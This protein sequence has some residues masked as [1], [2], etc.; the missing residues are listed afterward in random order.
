MATSMQKKEQKKK[1]GKSIEKSIKDIQLKFYTIVFLFG[2]FL[3]AVAQIISV[4]SSD[5]LLANVYSANAI[6]KSDYK[7]IDVSGISENGGSAQIITKNLGVI[8]LTGNGI[9]KEDK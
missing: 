6:I 7:S 2:I 8:T 5:K 4:L 9:I 3:F 1:C